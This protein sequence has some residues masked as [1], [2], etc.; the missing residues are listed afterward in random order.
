MVGLVLIGPALW[1]CRAAQSETAPRPGAATDSSA[2]SEGT[3]RASTRVVL[4]RQVNLRT[5]RAVRTLTETPPEIEVT[6]PDADL[7]IVR[8]RDAGMGHLQAFRLSTGASLWRKEPFRPCRDIWVAE[9]RVYGFC[10]DKL[11][12]YSLADGGLAVV[13]PGPQVVE[14][15]VRGRLVAAYRDDGVVSLYRAGTN[16][17]LAS[18]RLPELA[19]ALDGGLVIPRSSEGLCV[20]GRH[21]PERPPGSWAYKLGCYDGALSPR[22]RK[23]VSFRLSPE[24]A[25]A[26]LL[27]ITSQMVHQEGP[28]HLVL[29]DQQEVDQKQVN[30]VVVRWRD[31]LST[32]FQD[33]TY[34]T[35][36]D[37][38]GERVPAPGAL[39]AFAGGATTDVEHDFFG[40]SNAAVA[41]DRSRA[42]VLITDNRSPQLVAVD[43]RS[44][45]VLFR[46]PLRLGVL[47]H[48]LEV[49]EGLPIVRTQLWTKPSRWRATVHDPE[50]GRVLYE[51]E[52]P[53]APQD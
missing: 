2:P 7:A 51:D 27:T 16:R 46:V 39:A 32:T 42:Y 28:Y 15:T 8:V 48:T 52:R 9:G 1:S 12:S 4:G 22:W 50:T 49:A 14:A 53:A 21:V 19:R 6:V 45:R 44:A 40:S 17:R 38:R 20:Y 29:N 33:H 37:E 23:S 34:A 25:H 35:L 43:L 24:V 30:G 26:D 5:R 3:E 47:S 41:Y 31:G 11:L 10:G 36:E 18:N 13:D